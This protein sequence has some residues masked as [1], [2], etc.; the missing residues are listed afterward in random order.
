LKITVDSHVGFV[1]LFL[2]RTVKVKVG[3]SDFPH[4]LGSFWRGHK[5]EVESLGI[6]V[7]ML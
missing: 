2:Q 1:R 3:E 6:D 7:E 4:L 5:F